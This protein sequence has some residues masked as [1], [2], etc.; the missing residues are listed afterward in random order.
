MSKVK[1]FIHRGSAKP[2]HGLAHILKAT[3]IFKGFL[4]IRKVKTKLKVNKQKLKEQKTRQKTRQNKM[5]CKS[6]GQEELT[7][8]QP[9]QA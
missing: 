7:V 8:M 6:K 2:L 3:L 4:G 9:R 1:T 5:L